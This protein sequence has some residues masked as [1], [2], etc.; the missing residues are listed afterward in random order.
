[1]VRPH[2]FRISQEIAEH[3]NLAALPP[4]LPA[5]PHPRECIHAPPRSIADLLAGIAVDDRKAM[6]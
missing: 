3:G 6:K 5:S 4:G 1:M 2:T